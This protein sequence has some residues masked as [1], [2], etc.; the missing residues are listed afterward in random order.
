MMTTT[1]STRR[2]H[3]NP[4]VR[5]P[6]PSNELRSMT[7]LSKLAKHS[8]LSSKESVMRLL[9]LLNLAPRPV[10]KSSAKR[11]RSV[12][13]LD[14]SQLLKCLLRQD[15]LSQGKRRTCP[16]RLFLHQ[17]R[18]LPRPSLKSLNPRNS[19]SQ[20]PNVGALS[21]SSHLTTKTKILPC[22]LP[23]DLSDAQTKRMNPHSSPHQRSL[24]GRKRNVHLRRLARNLAAQNHRCWTETAISSGTRKR[25]TQVTR[26]A[27]ATLQTTWNGR[28]T[29]SSLKMTP[30][31][32]PRLHT[33]RR[34]CT[35][36]V[37]S[38]RRRWERLLRNSGGALQ[39]GSPLAG[40]ACQIT[41]EGTCPR[42]RL[43]R[44]TRSWMSMSMIASSCR[45]GRF[46]WTRTCG[47][48][49]QC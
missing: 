18:F 25:L 34:K 45:M 32:K 26:S 6:Q 2:G 11:D 9:L 29:A 5:P 7:I 44:L 21:Q 3:Q 31:R 42:A 12:H 15:L 47:Q 36:R 39:E 4:L 16:R 13:L 33:S 38:R 46:R 48:M 23:I 30:S 43:L 27:R 40:L 24:P 22:P 19:L 49:M 14:S 1:S 28:P 35:V 20:S 8:P 37:C 41:P 17:E 10:S